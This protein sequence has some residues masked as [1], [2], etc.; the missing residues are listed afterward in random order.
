[1]SLPE[2]EDLNEMAQL[3]GGKDFHQ[4]G[5]QTRERIVE[6]TNQN[7]IVDILA[8]MRDEAKEA[9]RALGNIEEWF[10][11]SDNYDKYLANGK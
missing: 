3:I 4:L 8:E 2:I 10:E 6:L 7:Y 11:R 1:M 5:P 9:S